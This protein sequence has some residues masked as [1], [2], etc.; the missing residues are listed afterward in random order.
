MNDQYKLFSDTAAFLS[1]ESRNV[2]KKLNKA[3]SEKEK[4]KIRQ[5][6]ANI[7]D[8]ISYEIKSIERFI[9]NNDM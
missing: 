1:Q 2:I 3:K 8:R 5:E 4:Q 9:Q 7:R 6:L